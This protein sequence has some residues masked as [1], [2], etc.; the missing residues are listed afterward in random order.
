MFD[1]KILIQ[2]RRLPTRVPRTRFSIE[3]TSY[4]VRR[5]NNIIYLC[6]YNTHNYNNFF[7]GYATVRHTM[8]FTIVHTKTPKKK[9]IRTCVTIFI[10]FHLVFILVP[11]VFPEKTRSYCYGKYLFSSQKLIYKNISCT[12][13]DIIVNRLV[14]ELD[15]TNNTIFPRA[16]SFYLYHDSPPD[17]GELQRRERQRAFST[18]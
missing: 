2:P 14:A 5:T 16:F 11:A 4:K 18:L 7:R 17:D 1:F 3:R 6:R 9:N 8:C 15:R 13:H 12:F 10:T